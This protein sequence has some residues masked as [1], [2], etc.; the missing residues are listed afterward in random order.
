MS[1]ALTLL[2]VSAMIKD[3]SK[4]STV[5]PLGLASCA[6]LPGTVPSAL[7]EDPVP[8]TVLT[9]PV[10]RS[11]IRMQWL[12]VSAQRTAHKQQHIQSTQTP[13]AKILG[14]RQSLICC[15]GGRGWDFFC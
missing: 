9:T 6:A 7:P 5:T 2:L 14:T 1:P 12:L 10:L 11:S 8:M 3:S 13:Y 15:Q 4:G